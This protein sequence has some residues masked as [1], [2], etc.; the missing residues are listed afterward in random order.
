MLKD[1]IK[2]KRK[3]STLAVLDIGSTKI[4]CLIANI[5]P[6]GKI[7]ILGIGHSESSGFRS[8]IITDRKLAEMSIITAIDI[9]E[10]MSEENIDKVI[11]TISSS[12][13]RSHKVKSKLQL[14][15]NI[16]NERDIDNLIKHT[17]D[18]FD[19]NRYEVMH[20]F[21]VEFS[22]DN[23]AD[24]KNPVGLF[25]YD[26][27]VLLHLITL[28]IP[29]VYNLI[30]CLADCHID[31]EEIVFSTYVAAFA[32]LTQDEKDIGV[33]LI[34]MGGAST[35]YAIFANNIL[36]HSGL[37]PLGGIN[38]TSDISKTLSISIKNAERIKTLYGSAIVTF[39]DNYKMIDIPLIGEEAEGKEISSISNANLNNII[40]ARIGE[41]F[42]LLK[43]ALNNAGI[44]KSLTERIVLTG[45]GSLVTGIKEFAM[46]N[47][48]S[49]V[50]VSKPKILDGLS[51]EDDLT[52][53]APAIGVIQ[54]ISDKLVQSNYSEN[55]DENKKQTTLEHVMSWVKENL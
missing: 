55:G 39:A 23:V 41:I 32:C 42:D 2:K 52:I 12:G 3:K 18:K 37:I 6:N 53:F 54:Q 28:P 7:K 21:P 43:I 25:G 9:A 36:I 45:G 19:A 40:A 29:L 20:Y 30:N 38:I 51:S 33:T 10:K 15:G 35:S 47:F 48:K 4:V 14:P 13:L 34:D 17:I 44:D 11:V 49:K 50:R 5:K 27:N 46:S 24:I 1:L 16:I 22:L 26:L 8:G 31:V